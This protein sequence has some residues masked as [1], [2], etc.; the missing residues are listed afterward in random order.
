MQIPVAARS[1]AWSCGR[2]LAGI[3][4]SNL[5]GGMDSL[6][7]VSV[8][9]CQ[10]ADSATGWSLVHYGCRAM[11]KKELPESFTSEMGRFDEKIIISS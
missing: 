3:A 4:G 8:M 1:K 11:K 7:L 9:C 6:S 10:I 2:S 5:A